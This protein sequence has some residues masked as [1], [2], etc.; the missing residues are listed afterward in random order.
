M[1]K[2]TDANQKEIVEAMRRMGA[3]VAVTSSL[4]Q[5]FPDLVVG[6]GR[7]LKLVELKDGSKPP[8]AR[9]LT[10]DE[11]AFHARWGEHVLTLL[12]VEEAI[13]FVNRLRMA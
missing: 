12:S 1:P 8:S 11:A 2:R 7:I 3:L 5:G 10:E 13:D 4:G 6:M 9:R